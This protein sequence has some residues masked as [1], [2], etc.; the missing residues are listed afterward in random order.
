[1]SKSKLSLLLFVLFSGHVTAGHNVIIGLEKPRGS[2]REKTITEVSVDNNENLTLYR[3]QELKK[4]SEAAEVSRPVSV[5]PPESHSVA[6]DVDKPGSRH[7]VA[8]SE[9]TQDKVKHSVSKTGIEASATLS[10]AVKKQPK[11]RTVTAK[12]LELW[13]TPMQYMMVVN[14]SPRVSIS[15]VTGDVQFHAQKGSLKSNVEALLSAAGASIPLVWSVSEQHFNPTDIWIDG[16]TTLDVLEKLMLSY[17]DPHP[18]K[19]RAWG[20]RVIEV[21][22]DTKNRR[23][24]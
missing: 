12:Q 9:Q 14:P 23:G 13:G 5:N 22:Y 21:Y 4:I 11:P 7:S 19:V 15:T 17:N 18:I 2:E 3:Y 6:V 1:M 16:A 8:I 20:N 24:N 10:D